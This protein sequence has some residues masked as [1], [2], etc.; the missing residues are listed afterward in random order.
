MKHFA[1]LFML[2]LP[3]VAK[4]EWTVLKAE[5]IVLALTGRVVAYERATQDFRA[6]GKTLYVTNAQQ[7]WGNWRVQGDQ[8]CSQWPPSDLWACYGLAR[9]GDRVRFVG[10]AGDITEGVYAD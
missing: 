7:S 3:D 1:L 10:E 2:C 8:Y 9:Q 5:D 4:A 6:S